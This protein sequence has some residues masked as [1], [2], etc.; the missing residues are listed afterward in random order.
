MADEGIL[1]I[2]LR[3]RR[4]VPLVAVFAVLAGLGMWHH[5]SGA[6]SGGFAQ[7]QVLLGAVSGRATPL[8]GVSPI[9]LLLKAPLLADQLGTESHG[10]QLAER[11]GIPRDQLAIRVPAYDG[12]A[13]DPIPNAVEASQ[14]AS[15]SA[16]PNVL[17]VRVADPQL[18]LIT[19]SAQA[20]DA[21]RAAAIVTAAVALL[22]KSVADATP[23]HARPDA[24]ILV[25]QLGPVRAKQVAARTKRVVAIA[26]GLLTFVFGCCALIVVTGIT[27]ARRRRA[28]VLPTA[29]QAA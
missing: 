8:D 9:T 7:T 22:N 12:V 24:K 18:P 15:G 17:L 26:A 25:Q 10:A 2:L 27:R 23:P 11:V 3:R 16:A 4:L 29:P 14:V 5:S 21:D 19:I 20:P 6:R 28:Q 13:P 1:E